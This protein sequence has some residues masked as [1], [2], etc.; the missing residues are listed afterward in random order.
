MVAVRRARLTK[1]WGDLED[2]SGHSSL[3]VMVLGAHGGRGVGP[4]GCTSPTV[5][6]IYFF[7]LS[8]DIP[9]SFFIESLA[10]LSFDIVS[11]FIES[12]D[13]A[14]LDMVSLLIESV[15][16]MLSLVA[17]WARAAGAPASE[18][19]ISP[20]SS[21]VAIRERVIIGYY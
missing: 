15:L 21:D 13:M 5:S 8:L 18:S 1:A 11:F 16:P 3:R 19:D 7:I 2:F 9:S 6:Q 10:M 4:H 14:S 20:A 17:V 12:F